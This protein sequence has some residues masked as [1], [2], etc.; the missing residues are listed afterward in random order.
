MKV[1]PTGGTKGRQMEA[2]LH[3]QL[4]ISLLWDSFPIGATLLVGPSQKQMG[5]HSS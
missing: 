1:K 4:A 2:R 5:Q 3:F